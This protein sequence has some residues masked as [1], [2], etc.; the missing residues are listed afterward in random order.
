MKTNLIQTCLL[1]AALLALP[2]AVQAQFTYT[3]NNGTITITGYTGS[4]GAVNIPATISGLPLTGIGV[5][6]FSTFS[7]KITLT[8]V[9]IPSS[10]TNIGIDAFVECDSLT[11]IIVDIN[12]PAYS[13]L[14]GVLFDKGH[15]A[16]IQY[17][18]GKTGSYLIPDSVTSVG[19]SAFEFSMGLTSVTI[20]NSVTNIGNFAFELT[21]LANITIPG[22]VTSIGDEVFGN[23]T[24][25]TNA[26]IADGVTRIGS[27]MFY[28]CTNLTS[29]T[30]PN[31]VTSIG[32]DAFDGCGLTSVT[33]SNSVTTIGDSAF[34]NCYHLTSITM[35]NGI[36]NIGD[37]TFAECV[38][39]TS[40]TIPDSVTNIGNEAFWDCY[41]LTNVTIGNDVASIGEFTFYSCGSLTSVTIPNGVVTIGDAAFFN[42]TSLTSVTVGNGVTNIGD[43]VFSNCNG[44]T[45]VYFSGNVPPNIGMNIF[46]GGSIVPIID[47]AMIYYLPNASGW[48]NTFAGRPTTMLT[49]PPQFGTTADGW[50]YVSDQVKY[51]LIDGYAGSNNVVVIPSLINGLP[52]TGIGSWAFLN[53]FTLA[54]VTIPDSMTSIGDDAFLYDYNLTNV[55][56]GNS[57]TSIGDSA[58][59]VLL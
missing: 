13:S 47:P 39:L 6:A 55:T 20:P 26:T 59:G 8:S 24:S 1:A 16:L 17:P 18:G 22:N 3:T 19:E 56:I 4:G 52:V 43:R 9:T 34:E 38:S 40:V 45:S 21:S 36:T 53:N 49:G 2:A 7:S 44:L 51:T 30:I 27:L 37:Y 32:D 25:L 33:L 11:A 50:N 48:S 10:V 28:N 54:S 23:C 29:V 14:A 42:C 31:S 15:T 58:F 35:G 57:V 12:N 5:Y 46:V 41:S